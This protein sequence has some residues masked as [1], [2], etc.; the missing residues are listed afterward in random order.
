MSAFPDPSLSLMNHIT[1]L[2]LPESQHLVLSQYTHTHTHTHN[3]T[4]THTQTHTHIHTR[5]LTHTLTLILSPILRLRLI[6]LTF[7]LTIT[8]TLTLTCILIFTHCQRASLLLTQQKLCTGSY[9]FAKVALSC[10]SGL[11]RLLDE[12]EPTLRK[13]QFE[14]ECT[15]IPGNKVI[16][17]LTKFD[18]S[19]IEVWTHG[20][21]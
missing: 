18:C 17:V 11:L 21:N 4:H 10:L 2:I 14:E 15:V 8:L 16:E 7:T 13:R 9:E 6:R 20:H 5:T 1:S 19:A 12:Y 3:H